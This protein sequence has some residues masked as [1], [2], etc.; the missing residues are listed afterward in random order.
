MISIQ[1]LSGLLLS[2]VYITGSFE[3]VRIM[4]EE[5]FG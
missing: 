3:S 1:V 2:M 4:M 5:M